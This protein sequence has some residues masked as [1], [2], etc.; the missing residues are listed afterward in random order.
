M[1]S[2]VDPPTKTV[3]YGA[4]QKYK[5]SVSAKKWV[6]IT[7]TF[8]VSYTLTVNTVG[9]GSVTKVPDQA[10]FIVGD[11]VTLTAVADAGW[12]FSGWSGDGSGSNN[13]L[14]VMMDADKSIAATFNQV[15]PPIIDVWYGTDQVFGQRSISW[16]MCQT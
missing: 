14:L 10:T 5:R 2:I 16:G 4:N 6:N 1:Y 8:P 3:W 11:V 7:E 9:N 15:E 13:P 12:E